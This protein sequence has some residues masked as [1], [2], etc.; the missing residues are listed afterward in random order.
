MGQWAALL[1]RGAQAA[2]CR[3][4][5]APMLHSGALVLL[6]GALSSLT[7]MPAAGA[8]GE[9]GPDTVAPAASR[10]PPTPRPR[11]NGSC[12]NRGAVERNVRFWVLGN[13]VAP[14]SP[15]K[16]GTAAAGHCKPYLLS[17]LTRYQDAISS[18]GIYSWTMQNHTMVDN[19]EH[20][21]PGFW[22]CVREIRRKFPHIKL[23]AVGPPGP[24]NSGMDEEFV[25]ITQHPK[26]FGET[27][28]AWVASHAGLVDELWTDFEPAEQSTG[29]LPANATINASNGGMPVDVKHCTPSSASVRCKTLRGI[30]AAHAVMQ[31]VVPTFAYVDCGNYWET[32]GSG[33][34]PPPGFNGP[35]AWSESC[36][37]FANGAPGVTLQAS[38]TYQDSGGFEQLLLQVRQHNWPSVHFWGRVCMPMCFLSRCAVCTCAGDRGHYQQRPLATQ[39]PAALPCDLPRLQQPGDHPHD[40]GALRS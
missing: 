3:G 6:L 5:G 31:A 32:T 14:A 9:N 17:N 7:A 10:V 29:L 8:G 35:G 23:G 40:D 30:N 20:T 26:Q 19:S 16:N 38:R 18:L 34:K 36:A 4:A 2:S 33:K 12:A 11:V 1:S 21:D 37:E 39:P 24:D 13:Q 15:P 25:W 28:R 27:V 22:P